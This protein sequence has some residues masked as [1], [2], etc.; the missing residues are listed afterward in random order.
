VKD[1]TKRIGSGEGDWKD[2]LNHPFFADNE[3]AHF[4]QQ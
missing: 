2:I 4:N 1:K 3:G